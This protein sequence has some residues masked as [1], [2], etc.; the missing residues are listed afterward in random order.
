MLKPYHEWDPQL[1]PVE[2]SIPADILVQTPVVE[3]LECPAPTSLLSL[4]PVVD[5]L[6]SKADEELTPTQTEDLTT[7][8]KEFDIFSGVPGR[9]TWGAPL[10]YPIRLSQ[11]KAKVLKDIHYVV[12]NCDQ[13]RTERV[14]AVVDLPAPTIRRQLQ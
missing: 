3:E 4:V 9:T 13:L 14:Q 2:T 12:L 10:M 1:D 7:S 8:L 6:L 11:E 5:T